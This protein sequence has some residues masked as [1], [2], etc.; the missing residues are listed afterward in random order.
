MKEVLPCPND[1]P[2]LDSVEVTEPQEIR[3]PPDLRSSSPNGSNVLAFFKRNAFVV[4]M[5][6]AVAFGK[7]SLRKVSFNL[8]YYCEVILQPAAFLSRINI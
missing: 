7:C 2:E 4:L 5:M 1:L 6:S 8:S 3:K